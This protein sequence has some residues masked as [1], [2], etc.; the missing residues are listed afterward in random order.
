MSEVRNPATD[1]PLPKPGREY[2][3]DH[4]IRGLDDQE[5]NDDL[6][7]TIIRAI[8]SRRAI[9]ISKYGVPLQTFNGRDALTDAWDEALDLWTYLNQIDMED[10]DAGS[11][12]DAALSIVTRLTKRR[13]WRG[14]EI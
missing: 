7:N 3:Q 10:G 11:L 1:Q 14:D 2:V 5:I 4:M 9:G 8:D 13:L 6:R 12:L